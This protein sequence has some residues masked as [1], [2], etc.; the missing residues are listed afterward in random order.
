MAEFVCKVA[1]TAGHVSEQLET[2]RSEGEVRERLADR[3][4]YVYSLRRKAVLPEL[5]WRWPRA[6]Q[7]VRHED[8]L[9]F[10]QQ[11]VTLVRAG[12]PILKALDL[13]SERAVRGRLREILADVRER[14][15]AGA[16]LSEAFE[17]QGI[18]PKIYT[19]SLL[20]GEKSGNL[21]GV[22]DQYVAYQRI[23]M[24]VRR[25]LL[26][27][28]IYPTLLVIL[29]TAILSYVAVGVI[30]EFARLYRDLGAELPPLTQLVIAVALNLRAYLVVVVPG[31]AIVVAGL[32]LWARTEAGAIFLD[33]MKQGTPVFGEVWTKFQ[34]AQC[35]RTLATLL[36]G[37]T[38]VVTALDTTAESMQSRLLS[39]AVTHAS[40][41]VREGQPLARSLAASGVFPELAV[42]MIEVGE[43]TGAL[44]QMLTSVAEFFE[45]DV[46]L[47][48]A[49]LMSLIEPAILIF[50]G[51]VVAII[52]ISLYL[53]I[54]SL[55]G[56]VR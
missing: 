52:L 17:G 12:L 39:S 1:D 8:F 16:L 26:A 38:P 51:L 22:L 6:R 47:R 42:E 34:T 49:A 20:A 36:I 44:P 56:Q 35:A 11:F 3:G 40:R 10:N 18:F 46:N 15:R 24:G 43:A 28:L 7:R 23:S 54:F 4:L 27:T 55:A 32:L 45:E 41:S 13:L 29:A 33:R 50:M 21:Q 19:T 31:V 14:V 53:P 25:K 37:G 9:V 2:G 48:L 30:P 5:A